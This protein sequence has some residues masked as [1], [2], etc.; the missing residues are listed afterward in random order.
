MCDIGHIP[1][2]FYNLILGL[3]WLVFLLH[4]CMTFSPYMD[5]FYHYDVANIRMN[6]DAPLTEILNEI[7]KYFNMTVLGVSSCL[8]LITVVVIGYRRRRTLAASHS[9]YEMRI[10][11]VA[12]VIFLVCSLEVLIVHFLIDFYDPRSL[13]A[14]ILMLVVQINWGWVNPI[15]YLCM[16]R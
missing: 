8:Y 14:M 15:V 5:F 9:Y 6:P 12:I 7:T 16:N 10:L 11:A 2:L 1:P 13:R 3:V 4:E